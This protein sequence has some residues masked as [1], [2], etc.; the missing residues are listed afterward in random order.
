[1]SEKKGE[2]SKILGLLEGA[3]DALGGPA[4]SAAKLIKNDEFSSLRAERIAAG[5]PP[6]SIL[7]YQRIVE[8]KSIPLPLHPFTYVT[9]KTFEMQLR[10]IKKNLKP[11]PLAELVQLVYHG[12]EID[13]KTVALTFDYGF[14]DFLQHAL[15]L[16]LRF[17][18]PATLCL[19]TGY[20]GSQTFLPIYRVAIGLHALKQLKQPIPKFKSFTPEFH[21][22]I[23]EVCEKG[24]ITERAI[25]RFLDG[26]L[27]LPA[28]EQMAIVTSFGE[29]LSSVIELPPY[30]DFFS[31]ADIQRMVDFGV[32]FCTMGNAALN[33]IGTPLELL[34]EDLQESMEQML[35]NEIPVEKYFCLPEG[36]F[37]ED[38]LRVLQRIGFKVALSVGDMPQLSD[39]KGPV[40]IL[41]R[42]QIS[43]NNAQTEALFACRVGRILKDGHAF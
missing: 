39:Q 11:V 6:W 5:I 19:A 22:N 18:M 21:K 12:K 35:Q 9:P 1:M 38:S 37:S 23:A 17:E 42:V 28:L 41:G 31:W 3:L 26:Y 36:S 13:P 24:Q 29:A 4:R 33:Y 7:R 14:T 8:P 34:F 32:T 20:I 30:Q 40:K 16:L 43:E 15:P 10:Y 27:A 2:G 25:L